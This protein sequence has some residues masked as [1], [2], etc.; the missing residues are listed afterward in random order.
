MSGVYPNWSSS[1]TYS[2]GAQVSYVGLIYRSLQTTRNNPPSTSPAFWAT[3]SPT[4][5][6][7]VSNVLAGNAITITGTAAAPI[8][9]NN[10]V[11]ALVA[12]SNITL[13]PVAPAPT[14]GTAYT[15]ASTSSGVQS[16]VAG[17]GIASTGGV[18]PSLSVKAGTGLTFDV[19]GN[20]AN[21]CVLTVSASGGCASTGG[22]NPEITNTGI[23]T[24]GAGSGIAST[25]GQNP[26]L[27]VKTGTGITI[28]SGGNVANS[29]ITGLTAVAGSGITF[30]GGQSPVYT[31]AYTNGYTTLDSTN[32]PPPANLTSWNGTA[33]ANY[34]FL[35]QPAFLCYNINDDASVGGVNLQVSFLTPSYTPGSY[36]IP[37]YGVP[38]YISNLAGANLY[39]YL[40]IGGGGSG[41]PTYTGTALTVAP[42]QTALLT[43]IYYVSGSGS[44]NTPLAII[45]SLIGSTRSNNN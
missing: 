30:P 28:D 35:Q 10:G 17:N 36:T 32:N 37:P 15:I 5:G 13:T 14:T 40:F 12:G 6:G 3:N 21:T 24:V 43:P 33:F 42:G 4:P 22:Q 20:V 9:N 31:P 8:V 1:T 2:T 44:Q 7:G 16:I 11:V 41:Q 26:S 19:S 23:I 18:N 45:S 34:L 39:L 25:G 27:S 29:G 38:S